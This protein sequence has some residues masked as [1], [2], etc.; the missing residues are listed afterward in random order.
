MMVFYDMQDNVSS[1][2]FFTEVKECSQLEKSLL[3]YLRY[4]TPT[5]EKIVWTLLE[6]CL[7]AVSGVLKLRCKRPRMIW[8]LQLWVKTLVLTEERDLEFEAQDYPS[9][10]CLYSSCRMQL[11]FVFICPKLDQP[12][13]ITLP[14][15]FSSQQKK[16]CFS[17]EYFIKSF[18]HFF[19]LIWWYEFYSEHQVLAVT[20]LRYRLLLSWLCTM[21]TTGDLWFLTIPIMHRC[22]CNGK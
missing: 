17:G 3:V 15:F 8:V 22:C 10:L 16:T 19:M 9:I 7:N 12:Y 13:K 18:Y 1:L 11:L 20:V 5:V 14:D 2:N 21:P 6:N 4:F